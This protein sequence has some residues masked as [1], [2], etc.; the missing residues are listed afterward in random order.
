MTRTQIIATRLLLLAAALAAWEFLPRYDIINPMLLP[1]LSD[2]IAMLGDLLTRPAVHE[3]IGVSAMEV[4][5]A[6]IIAVPLGTAIGVLLAESEY[7]GEIF[8]PII[9]YIFATPNSIFLPTFILVFGI[10]FQQKVAYAA[11]SATFIVLMSAMAAVEL[12]KSD[13]ILVARSYGA[14]RMQILMRVYLPSMLPI[15]LETLRIAM[16]FTFTG[17]MIAE[18]YASRTG[19]GHLIAGWGENFQMPQLLGG[20]II[21]AVVAIA[22]NEAVRY[23][24]VRCSRWRT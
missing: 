10:G 14:T 15:L 3:A 5:L 8:R 20:V 7:L 12:V 22:F 1:P 4:L 17:V 6:F 21:L 9:F 16:I 18:M 23:V 13:H 24:E 11:F 19:I 2:V